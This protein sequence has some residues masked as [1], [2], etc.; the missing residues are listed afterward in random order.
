MTDSS[1]IVSLASGLGGAVIGAAAAIYVP[2]R[3]R[4]HQSREEER[5]HSESLGHAEISKLTHLRSTGRAWFEVL[6]RAH[7]NLRAGVD[8]DLN[9]FDD[10]NTKT[11]NR[12]AFVGYQLASLVQVN[13]EVESL[14]AQIFDEL[15]DLS[16]KLR[17]RIVEGSGSRPDMPDFSGQIDR[18]REL[19]AALN[20]KLLE[21][22][23]RISREL[24]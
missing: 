2:A 14:S 10:D 16:W 22:I 9:R 18:I 24:R 21:R 11:G 19:R 17:E 1:A 15:Q 6:L 5:A 20:V 23:E 12:T 8:V 13:R 7:Q 3:Q 4:R